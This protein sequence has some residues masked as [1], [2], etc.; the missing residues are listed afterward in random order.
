MTGNGSGIRTLALRHLAVALGLAAALV[1]CGGGA[2]G[3]SLASV[4]PTGQEVE[5]WYQY[6]DAREAV[7]VD[8]ID[9]Y[10]ST[11]PYRIQVKG[12]YIGSHADI[13]NR[14]LQGIH[15]GPLPDLVVAYQNQATIYYRA[16]EVV[17]LTPYIHSAKW[18]LTTA[19]LADYFPSF[20]QQDN[21][22]GAQT[23][24]LPNRS[25]EMLYYNADW[26]RELGRDEPPHD[27]QQFEEL[28]LQ[29]AAHP[30]S[31]SLDPS[32]SLGIELSL[33]ASRLASMIFSRGGDI[34]DPA[35][36][37]YTLDTPQMRAS[38]TM[39]RSLVQAGAAGLERERDDGCAAF[40]RGQA[41]FA[42]QSS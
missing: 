27:W 5:F 34:L 3:D 41:L 38:L 35:G 30:F 28:C 4:D 29:A 36:T 19:E 40:G 2:D 11:N 31:R 13:Y 14:M 15:G 6:T 10:N 21:L 18:G 23:G 17:D 20:I 42:M 32:R 16:H 8:F 7:L 39:V 9:L 12:E 37:A 24:F 22:D 26:L 25:M 33:D 1:S